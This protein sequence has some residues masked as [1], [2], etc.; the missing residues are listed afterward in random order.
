MRLFEPDLSVQILPT[1][2]QNSRIKKKA[3]D[4]KNILDVQETNTA[5]DPKIE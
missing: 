1:R 2:A 3:G 5:S 4:R